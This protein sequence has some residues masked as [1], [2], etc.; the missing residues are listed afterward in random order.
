[1]RTREGSVIAP[2][3]FAH[4]G[5]E[6]CAYEC[7]PAG[8]AIPRFREIPAYA[9]FPYDV[10][11]RGTRPPAD[12]PGDPSPPQKGVHVRRARNAT[13]AVIAAAA[14]AGGSATALAGGGHHGH[15]DR[16]PAWGPLIA[17]NG[18]HQGALKHRTC[19]VPADKQLTTETS[20]ALA[21][22]DARL[23]A[24]VAANRI[25]QAQADERFARA[26]TRLS[27]AALLQDARIAPVLEVLGLTEQDLRDARDAGTTLGELLQEQ[28]VTPAAFR[29]AVVQGRRDARAALDALCPRQEKGRRARSG[30]GPVGPPA[31]AAPTTPAPP[32][33]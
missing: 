26:V 32:A 28:G 23:D 21:R 33:G 29:A 1:M 31:P 4:T 11:P 9:H 7:V 10:H 16:G 20:P 27:V 25:T 3:S 18:P 15:R 14:I 2:S 12:T 5:R 8:T 30:T 22:L 6:R 17:A 24:A 13:L 19:T